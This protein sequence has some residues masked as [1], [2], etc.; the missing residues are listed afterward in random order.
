MSSHERAG[1]WADEADVFQLD[2]IAD[3]NDFLLLTHGAENTAWGGTVHLD[4][5]TTRQGTLVPNATIGT[6]EWYPHLSREYAFNI[7]DMVEPKN[8][9]GHHTA[10]VATIFSYQHAARAMSEVLGEDYS[11]ED[12]R[13]SIS[14]I[15]ESPLAL[16]QITGILVK[17]VQAR[18]AVRNHEQRLRL[19]AQ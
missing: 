6:N 17:E 1:K 10:G 4:D 8:T 13:D 16:Q 7:P 19:A 18:V 11:A 15:Q 14:E 5:V 9:R 12:L 3:E 2:T